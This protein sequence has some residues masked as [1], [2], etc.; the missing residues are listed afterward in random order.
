M[1]R[2]EIELPVK[3]VIPNIFDSKLPPSIL[4]AVGVGKFPYECA[5][6]NNFPDAMV[7]QSENC[8][9]HSKSRDFERRFEN[10]DEF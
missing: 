3:I 6:A 8:W 9:T 1:N 7:Y 4:E 10:L 2:N 5:A